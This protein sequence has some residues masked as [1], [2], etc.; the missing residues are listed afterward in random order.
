[1]LDDGLDQHHAV[2]D[3]VAPVEAMPDPQDRV[4][5]QL[6]RGPIGAVLGGVA[7]GVDREL[8]SRLDLEVQLSIWSWVG[9]GTVIWRLLTM[10]SACPL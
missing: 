1:M 10:A 7:R 2:V 5:Q 8:L 4:K 6:A 9:P 3:A